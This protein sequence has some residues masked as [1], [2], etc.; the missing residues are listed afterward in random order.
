MD[1]S[2]KGC[3]L[4]PGD[5]PRTAAGPED[6][7]ADP[8]VNAADPFA[9]TASAPEILLGPNRRGEAAFT[10]TNLTGRPVR[11][12]MMPRG[13]DGAKDDW[14]SVL[15]G[16][17][18][19]PMAEVPMGMGATATV[20]VRI[21]VP[22][23]IGAGPYTLVLEVVAE[24]D[25]ERP[26]IGQSVAF[27]VPADSGPRNA[28]HLPW[29]IMAIGAGALILTGLAI[30]LALGLRHPNQPPTA[31]L[32]VSATSL[33]VGETLT[34]DGSAS[35]DDTAIRTYTIDWGDQQ[36]AAHEPKA[37]HTYAHPGSYTVTLTVGDGKLRATA[38]HQVSV[39]L[40]PPAVTG[41]EDF[42]VSAHADAGS[43][44]HC[45]TILNEHRLQPGWQID[46]DKGDPGHAGVTQISLEMNRQAE[47]SL[48]A[49]DYQPDGDNAVKVTGWICSNGLWG[50]EAIFNARYRVWT[51]KS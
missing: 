8:S 10:V 49:Y 38:A 15:V 4:G 12:R 14:M 41:S 29:A 13:R 35:T 32:V 23:D 30:A 36:P 45:V 18:E 40:P 25:T 26:V 6:L 44:G 21:A 50:S 33:T 51:I 3:E 27:T 9:V 34:A 28:H 11:V 47:R 22:T 1:G 43:G 7:G 39:T 24:D 37:T 19:V 31:H 5:V 2:A 16:T 42:T 48:M 17:A 20:N 46:R